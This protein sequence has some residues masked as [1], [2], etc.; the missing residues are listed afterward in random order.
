MILNLSRQIPLFTGTLLPVL[1]VM[2]YNYF[3]A[4]SKG[5]EPDIYIVAIATSVFCAFFISREINQRKKAELAL[6]KSLDEIA[7]FKSLFESAPGLYLILLPD[8]KIE[9]VSE[10]YLQATMTKRHEIMGRHLFEVFPDNPDDPAADGVRNL[11][12]SLKRV[13]STKAADA[14]AIQKY[15]IRKPDGAFEVRYWSPLNKPVLNAAGEVSYIIHSVVDVTQ[16]LINEDK[17]SKAAEEIKELYDKAP[18]GYLSVDSNIFLCNVNQ[19]LLQWLGYAPDEVLGKMKYEDLLTPASKEAHLSSFNEVFAR[20]LADGYINDLEYE[21]QRKDGTSFPAL[22]NS[23]AVFDNNGNF[24]K[25]RSTVFN[26]TEQKKAQEQLKAANKELES[27]SYSVSH[28]LRAPLRAISGYSQILTEDFGNELGNE[29][30][31]LLGLISQN[32]KKM[33]QLIDDLLDFSRLGRKELHKV[34]VPMHQVV[35]NVYRELNL[36]NN[37][38]N[39]EFIIHPLPTV[40]ADASSIR[41][42]WINLISNALK[43]SQQKEHAVIEVGAND[44]PDEIIFYVKDNGDGFDMRYAHKLF[45][46]FQRLHSDKEFSGTGVG[47]A[48][49]QRVITRHGGRVWAKGAKSEGA[50]FSFSLPKNVS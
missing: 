19:T 27:F 21:F 24:I 34:N 28:D 50:T 42:V 20:Y 4:G 17:I 2:A 33:G 32:S 16:R 43:Y 39:P 36:E 6:T 7:E 13:L 22:V 30:R 18:C 48:I 44:T 41:Q 12:A 1:Q 47:L 5:F 26:H 23:I 49:V 25:S 38:G 15:D 35:Q 14:M 46:V 37:T 40:Q 29:P 10:E 45:G 3:N 8:L 9:A 31:R 11:H